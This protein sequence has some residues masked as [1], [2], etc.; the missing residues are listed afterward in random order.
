MAEYTAM[1]TQGTE[2]LSIGGVVGDTIEEARERL[3]T[4]MDDEDW[5]LF[6]A[7]IRVDVEIFN[8]QNKLLWSGV[9]EP[10]EQ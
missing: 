4:L 9:L 7:A 8:D 5:S 2:S 6:I 3:K 1:L 10:L